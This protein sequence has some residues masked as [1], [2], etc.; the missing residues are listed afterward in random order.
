M[1][2]NW[3]NSYGRRHWN[4]VRRAQGFLS[5]S[6]GLSNIISKNDNISIKIEKRKV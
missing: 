6:G 5:A 4:D 1:I 3:T 2:F